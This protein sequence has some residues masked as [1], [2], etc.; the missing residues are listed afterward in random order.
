M[1]EKELLNLLKN[2]LENQEKLKA[3]IEELRMQN[4]KLSENHKKAILHS[5]SSKKREEI[6]KEEIL[7]SDLLE[8][9]VDFIIADAKLNPPRRRRR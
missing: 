6:E 1:K 3:E 2:I 4:K 5:L 7:S 8:K 9:C